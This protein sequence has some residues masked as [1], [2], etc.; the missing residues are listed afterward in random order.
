MGAWQLQRPTPC[1]HGNVICEEIWFVRTCDSW[2]HLSMYSMYTQVSSTAARVANCFAVTCLITYI[3]RALVCCVYACM[4]VCIYIYVCIFLFVY[5][6]LY[7]HV[8]IYVGVVFRR[9]LSDN[10]HL[11]GS[12]MYVCMYV[13]MYLCMY[14]WMYVCICKYVCAYLYVWM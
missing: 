4:Y 5:V 2:M 6:C 1:T 14:V 12:G 11:K 9:Y 3:S 10:V 7:V 13:C 8:C